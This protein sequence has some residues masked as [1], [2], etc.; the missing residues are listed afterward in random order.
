MVSS[1]NVVFDVVGTLIS[2]DHLFEAIDARL[3]PRL[4]EAG[5]QPKLL[6]CCWIETAEREYTYL[7]LSNRYVSF[8]EC[9]NALFYRMLH[10]SGISEPRKFCTKE[11]VEYLMAEWRKLD[12]RP[13]AA[14]CV[15]KLREAGFTVWCFTAGDLERVG[16]YFKRAGVDMPAANL[17]SCDTQGKAKPIPEAYKPILEKFA[18]GEGRPWFAAAHMWDVSTARTIGFKGAYTTIL[19]AEPLHEI[20][21]DMDVVAPSLP[22][23]ADAIIAAEG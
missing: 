12:L 8:L 7:S 1:K 10:Y 17:L 2:Y 6:G 4:R 15:S 9:M 22:E 19:E 14:E 13:G 11:D 16:G 23:M 5:I 20:F 21:G 3:G 18:D